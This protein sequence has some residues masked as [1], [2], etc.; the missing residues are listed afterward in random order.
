MSRFKKI[1][2]KGRTYYLGYPTRRD[3]IKA[4]NAGLDIVNIK[5]LSMQEVL[6]YSGLLAKQPEIT[7]EEAY[8]LMEEYIASDGDLDELTTYL[9]NQYTAFIKSPDGKKKKKAE[10]VEM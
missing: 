5:L 7:E 6:F 4:E 8:D 1:E 10:I 9:L 3:A 2:V